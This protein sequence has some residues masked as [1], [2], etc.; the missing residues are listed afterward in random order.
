MTDCL[1]RPVWTA[2]I[3]VNVV[4]QGMSAFLETLVEYLI[5]CRRI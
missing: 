5:I 4:V 2:N 3:N 1:L